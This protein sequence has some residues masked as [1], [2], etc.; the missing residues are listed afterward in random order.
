MLVSRPL[1]TLCTKLG[2]LVL[3]VHLL[4][5]TEFEFSREVD[6]GIIWMNDDCYLYDNKKLLHVTF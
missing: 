3:Q 5:P 4:N 6:T 1:P 2:E